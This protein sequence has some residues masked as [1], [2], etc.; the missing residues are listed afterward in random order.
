MKKLF[1]ISVVT[2]FL[3]SSAIAQ[4]IDLSIRSYS[5]AKN[6]NNESDPSF[7]ENKKSDLTELEL[8]N[9]S[10]QTRASFYSDFGY[11]PIINWEITDQFDKISFM[12]NNV[13][14]T[15]YYDSNSELVGTISNASVEDL[16]AHALQTINK[17]YKGYTVGNVV[18]YDDNES[19]QTD[20]MY[21]GQQFDDEDKYFVELQNDKEKIVVQV[22]TVGEVLFFHTLK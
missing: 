22:N 5:T 4:E 10:S 12:K 9:F 14:Y 8:K 19:N 18:F 6:Q 17:K 7:T 21:Y 13:L 20:M 2:L 11:I 16:P 15:A 1:I 3:A